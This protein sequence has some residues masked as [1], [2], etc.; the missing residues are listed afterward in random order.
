MFRFAILHLLFSLAALWLTTSTGEAAT[1]LESMSFSPDITVSTGGTTVPAGSLVNENLATGS[2][3]SIPTGPLP[4]G[5]RII[6]HTKLPGGDRLLAFDTTVELPGGVVVRPGDVAHY[7]GSTY[8]KYFDAASRGLP[9]SAMT[10]AIAVL[11]NGNLL[12]SF[13]TTVTVGGVTVKPSDLVSFNGSTWSTFFD[14]KE[15]GV[16]SGLN[17]D[18]AQLMPSGRLLLSF[19]GSGT[20]GGITFD[21]EDILEYDT[22]S[23][24]WEMAY[25]GSQRHAE[26]QHA[27]LVAFHAVPAPPTADL[28]VTITAPASFLLGNNLTYNISVTNAGPDPATG[29]TM[30]D[31]LPAGL[32]YVSVLPGKGIC[33]VNGGTIICD[34]GSMAVGETTSVTLVVKPTAPVTIAN[35]AT[36]TATEGDPVS[37]NNAGQ[38]TTTFVLGQPRISGAIASKTVVSQTATQKI[39]LVDLKLTNTGTGHARNVVIKQLV[40][41]TLYGSGTAVLTGPALPIAVGNLDVGASTITRLSFTVPATATRFSITE[42]GSVQDALGT[43]FNY[44]VVQSIIP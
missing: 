8:I 1:R 33:S 10:D 2:V 4:A 13:D 7:D 3:A 14:G 19:D 9:A 43:S 39:L 23:G 44:S 32:S 29:V 42:N 5:A 34:V 15:A 38:V 6:A 16:A 24:V 37:A 25:E 17:L 30:A 40:P 20:I 11:G 35:T 28:S 26:L 36:A 12:L 31:I 27:D 41:R 21:D 18:G 22:A